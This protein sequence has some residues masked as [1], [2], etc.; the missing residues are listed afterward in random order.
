MADSLDVA[1]DVVQVAGGRC[2]VGVGPGAVAECGAARVLDAP[3]VGWCDVTLTDAA[4]TDR[5]LGSLPRSSRV[6][7]YHHDTASI[8]PGATLLARNG[9]VVEA[10]RSAGGA[11]SPLPV[12]GTRSPS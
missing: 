12:T 9:E 10:V 11:T 6:M 2:H 8:P 1:E 5:V 4:T 3:E 7:Q